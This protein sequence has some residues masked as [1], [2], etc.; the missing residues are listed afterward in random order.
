M[1]IR[2]LETFTDYYG[3][4]EPL[5]LFINTIELMVLKIFLSMGQ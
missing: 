4:V 1:T 2:S 5:M 3:S